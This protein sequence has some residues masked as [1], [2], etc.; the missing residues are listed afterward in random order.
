LS[1]SSQFLESTKYETKGFGEHHGYILP[2]LL[3]LCPNVGPH[4][5]VLDVGCGNG[6][7]ASEFAK[8]GCP[9]VGI[10]LAEP[11]IRLAREACPSGRFELLPADANVLVNL[12]ERPFD[13]VYSLEVIEHLYDPRGFL[14]GCFTAT[15]SG[16]QFICSTPYHGYLKNLALSV[17]DKWDFHHNPLFDGGHIKFFSRK[18]L[19]AILVEAGFR[20]PQ[21]YG[22]GR[23]PFLWKSMLIACTKP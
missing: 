14:A 12:D 6:S 10:D 23:A 5:R 4:S 11:G 17:F 2:G 13:I 1:T 16:G 7:V 19:S 20:N 21:F 15:K 22:V 8:L 18:T 9:V 3:E